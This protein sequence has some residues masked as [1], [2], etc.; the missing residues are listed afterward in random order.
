MQTE[1]SH[2]ISNY[3]TYV[4]FVF[5]LVII[6]I[7]LVALFFPALITIQITGSAID[8]NPLET[9]AWIIPVL[10]ANLF[11]LGFGILYYKK[12]LPNKIR[13][14]V[15]FILRFEVSQ[16]VALLVV[17]SILFGYIGWSMNELSQYEGSLWGDFMNIKEII[18]AWPNTPG[19]QT[20]LEYL[21]VKNF[22]LKISE[23]AFQ[24]MRVLPF[25]ASISLLLL[26]YVFTVKITNKRFAGIVAMLVLVQ[27]NTFFQ[28]DTIASYS[29]FWGLFYLLSLYLIYKKW[30]LSPISF[31]ASIFSKPLT[32]AF[33]PMSLFFAYRAEIPKRKKMYLMIIYGAILVILAGIMLSGG[34]AIGHSTPFNP[35][36]DAFWSGFTT[37]TFQLRG[38]G[39]FFVFILPLTVGLFLTSRRGFKHADA[40]LFLIV[41]V[42]F[43]MPL[44][45][46]LTGFN[47]HPYRYVP[48]LVFFAVGV[49]T[50]L[51]QKKI[52]QQ[53]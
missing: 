37:W 15:K 45:T 28:F 42:I 49:G 4:V 11:L 5:A 27:S 19:T 39:L 35:D 41:G 26:T 23:V 24:N 33:A 53:A 16:N 12:I 36:M 44:L 22:F 51:S 47:I 34:S 31:V 52:T 43:S 17:I 40:I 1:K 20:S 48:L 38:D 50:L 10:T 29:N 25:M 46:A 18:T 9:S 7:N 2:L 6:L 21:H 14:S 30:Y 32:V 3:I 13:N 8:A